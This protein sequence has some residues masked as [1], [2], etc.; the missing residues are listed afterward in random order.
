[1]KS[2][3]TRQ[4]YQKRLEKFFDFTGLEGKTIEDKSITFVNRVKKES[5]DWTFINVLKFMQFQ[6][7]RANRKEITGST[8]RGLPRTKNYLDDRIPTME[9]I[10]KLL[11]CH[12][13]K[14]RT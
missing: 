7:V 8:V 10:R 14:Y 6:L 13:F 5:I 4:K 12:E 9:E 2:P 1:M 3:V 11:G